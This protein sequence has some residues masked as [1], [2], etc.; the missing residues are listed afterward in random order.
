M[1]MIVA[2]ERGF[3]SL[4]E[5]LARW[6]RILDFLQTADRFHGAFPHWMNGSTGKVQPF[7]SRDN[8]ADLVETAFFI[9]GLLTVRQ[10]LPGWFRK[11]RN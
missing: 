10:Y 3:I 11:R 4:E 6:R 8:G 7:S 2:V 9:Q 1:A 5:A